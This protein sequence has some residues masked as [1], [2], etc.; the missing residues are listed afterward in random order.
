[1]GIYRSR[2]EVLFIDM[3]D[4]IQGRSEAQIEILMSFPSFYHLIE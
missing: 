2:E 3:I 4:G 1:M